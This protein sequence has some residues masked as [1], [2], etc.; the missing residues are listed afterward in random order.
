MLPRLA[1]CVIRRTYAG[2]ARG[3]EAVLGRSLARSGLDGW[4]G[5]ILRGGDDHTVQ[6]YLPLSQMPTSSND[7]SEPRSVMLR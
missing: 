3:F 7:R 6:G 4:A 2:A 5:R 1:E